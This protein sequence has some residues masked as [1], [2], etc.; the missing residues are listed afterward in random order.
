[1]LG[2]ARAKFPQ[3]LIEKVGL[4]EMSFHQEFDG[5]V[6]MDALE[7]VPPEDW[8]VVM[9]NFYRAIKPHG[10]FYFTVEF[11]AE[12]EIAKAYQDGMQAG[13]PIVYGEWAYV[14]GYFGEW[15]Q[16]GGY[17]FYPRLEQ[18]RAWAQAAGFSLID[19]TVGEE[20]HHFLAQK[21]GA[22]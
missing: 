6:C 11:T 22:A 13:L 5:A 18:V 21:R 10:Y 17:H 14:G 4:Q 9:G 2:R 7:M 16:E 19:E 3:V 20:Y 12:E 1:M 15:A 8:P